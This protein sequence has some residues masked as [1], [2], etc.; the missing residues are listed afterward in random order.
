MKNCLLVL[1]AGAMLCVPFGCNRQDDEGPAS[2]DRDVDGPP[3]A[4]RTPLPDYDIID[5]PSAVRNRREALRE[6]IDDT[7]G[8]AED[9]TGPK[10]E[11]SEDEIAE[12]KEVIEKVLATKD[13]EDDSEAFA[14]FE[15]DAAT[16]VKEITQGTKDIQAKALALDAIMETKFGAQ[17]P[18]SVKA[19][20]KQMQTKSLGPSSAAEMLGEISMDQLVFTK[21]GEK[22]VATGS[23]KDKFILSKTADGWKIGFD[24]NTREMIGVLREL[25]KG[26]TK[27]LEA[28]SA[29]VED[30]SITADNIEDKAKALAEQHVKPFAEKFAAIM[31]KAM[32]GAMDGAPDDG[33]APDDAGNAD[34]ATQ[35]AAGGAATT[36]ADDDI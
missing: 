22:I 30:D 18:D 8:G 27:L 31:M 4:R 36:D 35:P 17:Y 28:L 16:A 1:I 24:K 20:N 5:K 7:S 11:A 32:A 34:T 9:L 14:F 33:T 12:V 21:I 6:S 3:V 26:T 29:G 13:A 25:L 2:Y 15:E 19:K 23:R 10:S